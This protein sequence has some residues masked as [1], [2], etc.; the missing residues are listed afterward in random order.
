MQA[1]PA[2]GFRGF[3]RSKVGRVLLVVFVLGV[4][5]GT[6]ASEPNASAT[7]LAIPVF[8]AAGLALPI[9]VGLKRPR[10]LAVS[11]LVVLLA[12]APLATIVFSQD[13]LA[14]PSTA[15][16]AGTAPNEAGGSVLQDASVTPYSGSSSAMFTWNVSLYPKFLGKS[17]NTTNWSNDALDL[18]IS[19]CPGA[20]APNLSYCGGGY[21]LIT[22]A[23]TFSKA[24]PPANGSVVTFQQHLSENGLWS[25]QMVLILQNSSNASN[26]FEI[27]LVGD[28]TYDGLAGPIVGGFAVVYGLLIVSVYVIVLIYLGIPF[29]FALLL[30]MWFKGR[31]ARRK[32][33]ERRAANAK[34]ALA[35]GPPGEGAAGGSG[36]ASGPPGSTGSAPPV[37]SELA[38]PS[39][40]AVIYP[41][42]SKCW[43]CGAP[44]GGA[45]ASTPPLPSTSK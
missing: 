32:E 2:G 20:T 27:E 11:G 29:Y 37:A 17:L 16:T 25:W 13:A 28:P 30:Y 14:P 26:P 38:C 23:H 35:G 1:K 15:S 18:Y 36:P 21:T 41:N 3:L 4:V 12:V 5:F 6:E 10:Y 8:L 7:I 33:A 43:K 40:G 19:S 39:C 45:P 44:V 22:L 9:Y 31:E 42:E 34:A 24:S